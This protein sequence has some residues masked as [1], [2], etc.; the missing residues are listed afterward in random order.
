MSKKTLI[1]KRSLQAPKKEPVVEPEIKE[2]VHEE[3]FPDEVEKKVPEPTPE[4][5]Q[6]GAQQLQ[7]VAA[8]HIEGFEAPELAE[9]VAL[10][11]LIYGPPGAGKSYFVYG[12]PASPA[13]PIYIIRTKPLDVTVNKYRAR[14]KD[15]T[16]R[17]FKCFDPKQ[18]DPEKWNYETVAHR[19][20]I[21]ALRLAHIQEGTVVLDD[22]TDFY[23]G[24]Q[25]W[26]EN[27]TD[28]KR[29]QKD[30]KPI[31]M[32]WGRIYDKLMTALTQ[33]YWNPKI[34]L[35]I[36]SQV[37]EQFD[38]KGKVQIEEGL[39]SGIHEAKAPMEIMHLIDYKMEIAR[40]WE[41]G[42]EIRDYMDGIPASEELTN[43]CSFKKVRN[44]VN[45][46]KRD[47]FYDFTYPNLRKYMLA[48][49]VDYYQPPNCES[50]VP[51]PR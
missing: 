34:T 20:Q 37:K 51:D 6:Q 39:T 28:V 16:I 3:D 49:G 25:S 11:C 32:E 36:V 4:Q 27:L 42:D 30:Q 43:I 24:L 40:V 9:D 44:W 31:R 18:P 10:K 50:F 12:L 14:G 17:V 19:V 33:I 26:M 21:A 1:R 48:K 22:V 41:F 23:K 15:G 38:K 2:Q 47:R 13:A 29:N 35:I 45:N 46:P 5:F 8:A 7:Q